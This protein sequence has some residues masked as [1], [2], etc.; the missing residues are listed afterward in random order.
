[1]VWDTKWD[2]GQVVVAASPVVVL[3]N[4]GIYVDIEITSVRD[5][6]DAKWWHH[7]NNLTEDA[8]ES[9]NSSYL[10]RCIFTLFNAFYVES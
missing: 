2:W 7:R 6:L 10:V 1:M 8:V 4:D 9:W 3:F 5:M